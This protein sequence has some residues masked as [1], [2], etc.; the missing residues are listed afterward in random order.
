VR[1]KVVRHLTVVGLV[2]VLAAI[3]AGAA[4]ADY[5]YVPTQTMS[6]GQSLYSTYNN[7]TV[8]RVWHPSATLFCVWFEVSGGAQKA[9][10]QCTTGNPTTTA[11]GGYGYN[12]AYCSSGASSDVNPVTCRVYL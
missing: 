11:P 3:A 8:N 12:R 9:G 1:K 4:F 2:T 7:W 10:E 6:P 5:D